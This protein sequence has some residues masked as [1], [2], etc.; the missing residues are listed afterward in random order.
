[1]LSYMLIQ[2]R[3]FCDGVCQIGAIYLWTYVYNLMR[4]LA[5]LGG[6]TAI[7]PT[8]STVPLISPK[9]EQVEQKVSFFVSFLWAYYC[10][11]LLFFLW[12]LYMWQGRDL[13]QDQAKSEFC[14]RENQSTNN[15]CSFNYCSG[16]LHF[17]AP[18]NKKR[19]LLPSVCS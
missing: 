17:I 6:D 5:N 1:M 7:I 2:D 3:T 19:V 13:E 4:M 10:F 15:I 11:K 9:A 14:S 16:L 8:S 18:L 12:E